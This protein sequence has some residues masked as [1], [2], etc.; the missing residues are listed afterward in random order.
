MAEGRPGRINSNAGGVWSAEEGT[1]VE[2][3]GRKPNGRAVLVRMPQDARLEKKAGRRCWIP[4]RWVDEDASPH[5]CPTCG[6]L[7]KEN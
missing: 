7:I 3:L 2:V 1:A 4:A 6:A 5:T